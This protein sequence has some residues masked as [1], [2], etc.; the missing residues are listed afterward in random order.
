MHRSIS[1]NGTGTK[2]DIYRPTDYIEISLYNYTH[3]VQDQ[4]A[5][6]I[7]WNKDILSTS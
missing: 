4:V 2:T 5:K 1:S 3:P 7:C 6:N